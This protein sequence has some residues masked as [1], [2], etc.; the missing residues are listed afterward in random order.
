MTRTNLT[1]HLWPLVAAALVEDAVEIDVD[2]F[3]VLA[4]EQNVL[5]VAISEPDQVA[6]HA[7]HGQ[8]AN[9]ARARLEPSIGVGEV[10]EE[11]AGKHR[12]FV[13]REDQV[14]ELSFAFAE[15]MR[16]SKV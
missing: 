15:R 1:A 5:P 12:L 13:G 7:H 9:V 14:Q 3:S 6:D 8:R 16:S 11:P 2:N 4:V 10:L